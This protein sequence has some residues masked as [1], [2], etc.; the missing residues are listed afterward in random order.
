M[1]QT[2]ALQHCFSHIFF[3][4]DGNLLSNTNISTAS[5]PRVNVIH[6]D[7][8]WHGLPI[9]ESWEQLPVAVS[10]VNWG[11]FWRVRESVPQRVQPQVAVPRLG[12]CR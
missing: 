4:F 5:H 8:W 10:V 11:K 7:V 2:K 12:A 3:L 1:Q 9:L 6:A